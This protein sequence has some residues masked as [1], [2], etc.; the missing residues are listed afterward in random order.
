MDKFIFDFENE[1]FRIEE[2][3]ATFEHQIPGLKENREKILEA[4]GIKIMEMKEFN[5]AIEDFLA[6]KLDKEELVKKITEAAMDAV[7]SQF[8]EELN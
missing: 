8:P 4:A 6:G 3:N 7:K 2:N 5:T 1:T